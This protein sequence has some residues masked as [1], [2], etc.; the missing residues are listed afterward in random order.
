[1][2]ES[3]MI[4]DLITNLGVPIAVMVVC[5]CVIAK[6]WKYYTKELQ[7]QAERH[8]GDLEDLNNKLTASYKAQ[9][10]VTIQCNDTVKMLTDTLKKER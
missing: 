7:I 5:M 2:E 1:M 4:I 8:R 3:P 9:I 10:E 6:M